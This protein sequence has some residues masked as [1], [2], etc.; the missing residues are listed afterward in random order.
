MIDIRLY[1]NTG[2]YADLQSSSELMSANALADIPAYGVEVI[3]NKVVKF[4]L[5]AYGSDVLDPEYGGWAFTHS[6]MA[7]SYIPK[8]TLELQDDI[9]RCLGYVNAAESSMDSTAEKLQAISIKSIDYNAVLT[10]DRLDVTLEIYTT[11]NRT[12]VLSLPRSL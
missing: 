9:A 2:T 3:A 11:Y 12:A 4:L 7:E 10:P 1:T 8:F 6:Q 5:T